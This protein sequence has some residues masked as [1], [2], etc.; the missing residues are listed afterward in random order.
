MAA[1]DPTHAA[2]GRVVAAEGVSNFGSSL[3]RLAIPWV[4]TPLL[5]AMPTATTPC[6]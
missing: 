3:S 4:V 2:I 5:D 1:R 6:Q